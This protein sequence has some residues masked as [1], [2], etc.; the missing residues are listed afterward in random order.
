MVLCIDG[1]CTIS[2][3]WYA[4]LVHGSRLTV[5]KMCHA[6]LVVVNKSVLGVSILTVCEGSN[7]VFVFCTILFCLYVI[8]H[9]NSSQEIREMPLRS[10]V[11]GNN[12][13]GNG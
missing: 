11:F 7:T 2:V 5:V 12:A 13:N 6:H 9:V 4:W 10:P 1:F 3:A 8:T